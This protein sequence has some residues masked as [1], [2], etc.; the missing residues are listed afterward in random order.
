MS[1]PKYLHT[2]KCLSFP[3][4]TIGSLLQSPTNQ[5]APVLGKQTRSSTILNS[6]KCLVLQ[7]TK[8][9]ITWY[10]LQI[11]LSFINTFK[12]I[13][14]YTICKKKIIVTL[15]LQSQKIKYKQK[16]T[17]NKTTPRRSSLDILH[18]KQCIKENLPKMENEGVLL[19]IILIQHR[20]FKQPQSE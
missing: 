11:H 16:K 4:L 19:W 14:K 13:I 5:P 2:D 7:I 15:N 6:K 1:L 20:T 10:C 3:L 17:K 18:F 9:R 12:N 8:S